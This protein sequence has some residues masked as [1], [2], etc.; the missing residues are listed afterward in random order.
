MHCGYPRAGMPTSS[1]AGASTPTGLERAGEVA[2]RASSL[3][4]SDPRVRSGLH[5]GIA[6]VVVL[7][8]G[9]AAFTAA[10]D[11]PDIDTDRGVHHVRRARFG[12]GARR[13]SSHGIVAN[14]GGWLRRAHRDDD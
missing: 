8:V 3:Q 9:L 11:L 1:E 4:P 6:I 14:S 12:S 5:A 7:S 10:G 2:A 13:I